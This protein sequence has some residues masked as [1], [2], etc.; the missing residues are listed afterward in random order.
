MAKFSTRFLP[1]AFKR[2]VSTFVYNDVLSPACFQKNIC[3]ICWLMRI[4]SGRFREELSSTEY[5]AYSGAMQLFFIWGQLGTKTDSSQL[6]LRFNIINHL[7]SPRRPETL[8]TYHTRSRWLISLAR[9]RLQ[10]MFSQSSFHKYKA[11]LLFL[12]SPYKAKQ[13]KIYPSADVSTKDALAV[14]FI[15]PYKNFDIWMQ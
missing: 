10:N 9:F 2:A 5:Y 13:S 8:H 4:L 11:A 6:E 12:F 1:V 7:I 3:G 14:H 15:S